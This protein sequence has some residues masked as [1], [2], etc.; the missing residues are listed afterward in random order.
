MNAIKTLL[1]YFT[2]IVRFQSRVNL[3]NAWVV[4][5]QG[6]R[7]REV[8]V[9]KRG[10]QGKQLFERK[11]CLIATADLSCAANEVLAIQPCVS[12]WDSVTATITCCCC[13]LLQA[14]DV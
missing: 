7:E 9:R 14:A 13:V 8:R 10:G 5:I 1:P 4:S 12:C 11:R 3:K 6:E 2:D